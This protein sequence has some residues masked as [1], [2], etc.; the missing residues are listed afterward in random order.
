[1]THHKEDEAVWPT[2]T[3]QDLLRAA[4]LADKLEHEPVAECPEFEH[5]EDGAIILPSEFNYGPAVGDLMWFASEFAPAQGFDWGKWQGEAARLAN[6]PEA[7]AKADLITI[8]KLLYL[9][10][11]KE[12]FCLGHWA[13]AHRCGHL[14]AIASRLG[15]LAGEMD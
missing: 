1:V 2:P 15:V 10:W 7:L 5:T 9:H 6:D 3:K 14:A 13:A 4:G 12:R 8:Q 11:R